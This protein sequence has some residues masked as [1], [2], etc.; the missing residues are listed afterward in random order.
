M[1]YHAFQRIRYEVHI[2]LNVIIL[3]KAWRK[4][5]GSLINLL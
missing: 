2:N 1:K 4:K 5:P 3:S